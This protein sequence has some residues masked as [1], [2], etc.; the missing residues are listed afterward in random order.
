MKYV[1]DGYIENNHTDI[2]L[3][4]KTGNSIEEE[5]RYKISHYAKIITTGDGNKSYFARTHQSSL[6]DP[7]GP[8]GKREKYLETKINKVSK[9]TFDFYMTYLKTNNSIYLTKA[10]RGFLND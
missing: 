9:A 10:Q 5:K 4:D 6:F 8:Y 2:L 7:N 3:F 1:E